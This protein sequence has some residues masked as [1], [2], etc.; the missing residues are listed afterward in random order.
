ML[1]AA[2][3]ITDRFGKLDGYTDNDGNSASFDGNSN[4]APDPEANQVVSL[5]S[6][7]SDTRGT[8]VPATGPVLPCAAGPV[9]GN[10]EAARIPSQDV[11]TKEAVV[12]PLAFVAPGLARAE[13]PPRIVKTVLRGP[14]APQGVPTEVLLPAGWTPGQPALLM[15][16]LHDGWGNERSFRKH[17]LAAVAIGMMQDGTIP[18]VIIA[19]PRHRGTF[20]ADSPRAAMESLVA[21]DLVPAL[22]SAFPGAGGSPERRSVWGI[23]M[24]G[25]GALK[26]ALRHPGVYGRVAALAPWVQL[27]SWESYERNRTWWWSRLLEPVFGRTREESRFEINDL[28][29]I[30]AATDP[31]QVP[32]LFIRTG[33]RDR[34]EKGADDLIAI[35][36]QRGI[37]VDAASIPEAEHRWSDWRRA[38]PALLT[39]LTRLGT[40]ESTR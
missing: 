24:G 19:S 39:F 36:R 5:L 15:V 9:L 10:D 4:D 12:F 32:P 23:L 16:F 20:I 7:T 37:A 22:E 2:A 34:R 6:S 31:A 8:P 14:H 13:N 35:L 33:S 25:Y 27:L 3:D 1:A 21:D 38:M 30:A 26:M 28:A 18:R 17:G 29:S 40:G 11:M